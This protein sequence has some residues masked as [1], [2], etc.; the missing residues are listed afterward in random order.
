MT[1]QL[2]KGYA[3]R[4]ED[5]KRDRARYIQSRAKKKNQA[6][7]KVRSYRA[8]QLEVLSMDKTNM[9]HAENRIL[10]E[11]NEMLEEQRLVQV[12]RISELVW[13]KSELMLENSELRSK[14]IGWRAFSCFCAG[15]YIIMMGFAFG[16]WG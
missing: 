4:M 9:V 1:A 12:Q 5:R 15:G 7:Y 6:P 13:D 11:E 16:W 10:R 14:V 8:K 3:R 2:A